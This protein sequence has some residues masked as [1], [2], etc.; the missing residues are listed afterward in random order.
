M[1]VKD[2][3][4]LIV[5]CEQFDFNNPQIDPVELAQSLVTEMLRHNGLGL[6]AN[7]IGYNLRVFAIRGYPEHFVMFNPMIIDISND[8]IV[9]EEGCLSFPGLIVKIKRPR[10]IRIR[11]YGPN[12]EMFI[13]EF[14]DMTA[15]VIQHEI[16]H[17][18]GILFYNRANKYH[19]DQAFR[20]LKNE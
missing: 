19:R 13:K 10:T 16:D 17:L 4:Q 2:F 18:N 7:Q 9:L 11:F 3:N 20:R 8:Q 5:P 15:R 6:A 12:G 1:I 14:I